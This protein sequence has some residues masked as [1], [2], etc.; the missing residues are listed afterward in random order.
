LALEVAPGLDE[1]LL[2]KYI[3]VYETPGGEFSQASYV[4]IEVYARQIVEQ[5]A[6]LLNPPVAGSPTTATPQEHGA[7]PVKAY[8]LAIIRKEYNQAYAPWSEEDDE[9]LRVR[10]LEGASLEDLVS[11]FGRQ[12]GGI[13]SRLRKLGLEGPGG[14]SRPTA[15]ES[16][17]ESG[18][19]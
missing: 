12:P 4:E 5:L 13:R 6:L 9:Y 19:A 14:V 11:E 2:G 10:F 8:D 3:G 16:E 1:R 17:A 7:A 18:Y 15:Q